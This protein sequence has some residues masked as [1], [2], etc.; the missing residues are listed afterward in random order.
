VIHEQPDNVGD[1]A[2]ESDEDVVNGNNG[3]VVTP[4]NNASYSPTNAAEET[5][6]LNTDFSLGHNI[7]CPSSPTG[8]GKRHSSFENKLRRGLQTMDLPKG[9]SSA[10]PKFKRLFS[11]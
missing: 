11:S 9:P 4:E 3:D 5:A 1:D 7:R 8:S 10:A 6:E 2:P